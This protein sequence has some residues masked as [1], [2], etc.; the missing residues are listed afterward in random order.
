[1]VTINGVRRLLASAILLIAASAAAQ[2]PQATSP[3]PQ[4]SGNLQ[5]A[6][7]L[8][9][10]FTADALYSRSNFWGFDCGP[11]SLQ[12]DGNGGLQDGEDFLAAIY[13]LE[14]ADW[15]VS[16]LLRI[17]A[18]GPSG[19]PVRELWLLTHRGSLDLIA[20]RSLNSEMSKLGGWYTDIPAGR[21]A[22]DVMTT[23]TMDASG[24]RGFEAAAGLHSPRLGFWAGWASLDRSVVLSYAA[25]TGTAGLYGYTFIDTTNGEGITLARFGFQND[26]QL[27]GCYD[28]SWGLPTIRALGGV[29]PFQGNDLGLFQGGDW[30]VELGRAH[31]A[32]TAYLQ[33]LVG[34]RWVHWSEGKLS[35]ATGPR[36]DEV[37]NRWKAIYEVRVDQSVGGKELYLILRGPGATATAGVAIGF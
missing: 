24:R 33:A 34:R 3:S 16:P 13:R 1:L 22:L 5:L 27:A 25:N 36:Y 28:L 30:G 20:Q 14:I 18:G 26:G 10:P 2:P 11:L 35:A 23:A 32:D 8:K 12:I 6:S 4:C 37:R 31:F 17:S 9:D 21:V 15:K 29:P 19:E 7:A